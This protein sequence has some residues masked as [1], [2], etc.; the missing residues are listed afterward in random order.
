MEAILNPTQIVLSG[1]IY[2][3]TPFTFLVA[4]AFYAAARWSQDSTWTNGAL[5]GFA[6]AAATFTRVSIAP[7]AFCAIGLLLASSIWQKKPLRQFAGLAVTTVIVCLSLAA[8][9]L[10]NH[11]QYGTF[12]L[13]SQGGDHLAIFIVPL[14]KEMQDRTPFMVTAEQMVERA[15]QRFGPPS[16]DPFEQSRRYQEIG[17]EALRS[18]IKLSALAKSWS[19]GIFINLASPAHLLSPPVSRLPRTGFYETPGSSFVEKVFNYAFRSGNATYSW[20][21]V[22]GTIGLAGIRTVQ[23]I[24]LWALIIERRH[25]PKL[26]FAASW[27][28]FLLLLNGPIASPKYRLPL[29][30]LFNI[31]TGAGIV[32]ICAWHKRSTTSEKPVTQG[33]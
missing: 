10:R 30:P 23:V 26:V 33:S 11:A 20:L 21:L 12:A 3:D 16:A 1:L 6:L 19:S 18:E 28:V 25:W 27:I 8:I 5:L 17:W 9:V 32:S 4:L 7:W 22:L 2:T 14:A 15:N 24:G 13:T 31:L 29:E